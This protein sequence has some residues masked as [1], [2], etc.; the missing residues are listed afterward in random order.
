M[1]ANI[2]PTFAFSDMVNF[3]RDNA[4]VDQHFCM[5]E[6]DTMHQKAKCIDDLDM[7]LEVI[8]TYLYGY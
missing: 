7:E 6:I 2:D 1:L 8:Q 4:K 5:A 3:F